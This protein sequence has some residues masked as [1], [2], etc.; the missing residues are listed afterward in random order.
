MVRKGFI[1]P[2]IILLIIGGI[3]AA[4]LYPM[5]GYDSAE[6]TQAKLD[7]ELG[8]WSIGGATGV[9]VEFKGTVEMLGSGLIEEYDLDW[10]SDLAGIEVVMVRGVEAVILTDNTD[11]SI[12]DEVTVEGYAF[13]A[14]GYV[15]IIGESGAS[16]ASKIVSG[17]WSSL[18]L[19]E[20]ENVPHTS[21]YFGLGVLIL[22]GILFILGL[23]I[24]KKKKHKKHKKN[25]GY[26]QQPYE[27]YP[28]SPPPAQ[29]AAPPYDGRAGGDHPPQQ[30][31][32]YYDRGREG[33]PPRRDDHYDRGREGPPPRRDDHYDRGR[34]GQPSRRDDHYDRG[35]EGQP[36][37]RREPDR[38]C[39]RC[40]TPL[41]YV[42][43]YSRWWCDRCQDY[44]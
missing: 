31:D 36:P 38:K 35:R 39:Y 40:G 8:G 9:E 34:E 32:D 26:S 23:A 3:L 4:W 25:K 41:I 43:R 13:G 17:A 19:A 20:V 42:N 14:S 22:G 44:D 30:R 27:S 18:D 28:Q 10:I 12:G 16:A 6:E 5:W 1:T 33:P 21:F 15:F 7:D 2:G 29:P 24:P 37:A 11:I